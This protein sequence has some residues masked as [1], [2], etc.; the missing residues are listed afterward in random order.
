MRVLTAAE[1]G[2]AD[3]RT[4]D[5][6][7]SQQTLMENA[8]ECVASFC[9][10]QYPEAAHVLVLCGKGN[11]GGDGLTAARML[12]AEGV[13]VRVLLF[14][15]RA[16][17]KGEAAEALR[18]LEE[19]TDEDVVAE[20]DDSVTVEDLADLLA[21]ADLLVDAV[22]G[23]G[24]KGPIR[25]GAAASLR[26]ALTAVKVPVVAVDLPSGW[27]ADSYEEKV[28][29]AYRADAVITFTAPKVAHCFGHLTANVFGPVVVGE[30]G[31]PQ[32]AVQSELGITWTGVSKG[33]TETARPVN[34]NKG[35]FGHVLVVGG[36]HGT[37][38]APSMASLS[39]MRAGAGLVTAAVPRG[40]VN[41]VGGIA[42]ELM[43]L[44]L[45]EGPEGSVNL[46]N[47][48]HLD[49]LLRGINVLAIGPGL[50]TKGDAGKFARELIASTV[51]PV[52]IDADGLNAFDCEQVK[53][54]SGVGRTLVITPHPGE[55]A[56]LLGVSVKEVEADRI[57]LAR[58]F[59]ME[60][61]LILVLKGW[62]TLVAHPDG[63]IAVNTTGNPSLAKGGSGDILT[64]IVA[65]LLAQFPEQV[66]EAVEAAVYL[67]GL[68]ADLVAQQMD[69]KTVLATDVI[70]HLSA[71]FRYRVQDEDEL[72]WI[73]GVRERRTVVPA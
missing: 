17:V 55:M 11:N 25:V 40:I 5:G 14:G 35:S 23:T 8:G 34:S 2:A 1:M 15:T 44:G 38:G 30:I 53:G 64:G 22:L 61:Q 19:Q 41:V 72:T 67:H 59:A 66:A 48:D 58:K 3:K 20:V 62:R 21:E 12:A 39:C 43:V 49:E 29:G 33:L 63:R 9:L 16:A 42:P 18:R 37:A 50:S 65:A 7:V 10:R 31:S 24:F 36:S 73:C 60:H 71:A 13:G 32:N 52:V 45:D 54:L 27:D 51:L 46:G 4:A 69:E 70:A 26:D 56:R 6:G 28:P 68:A 47:L 57:G